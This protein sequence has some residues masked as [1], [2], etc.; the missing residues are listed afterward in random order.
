MNIRAWMAFTPLW[1]LFSY[2]VG[3]FS[4]WGGGFLYQWGVIDYSGGYVIHL[5]S[6]IAGFTA[7]YWVNVTLVPNNRITR[8]SVPLYN[9]T[10]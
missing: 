5:S 9:I 3:A 10:T 6:G 8:I 2:T 1:L 7:A 4:L